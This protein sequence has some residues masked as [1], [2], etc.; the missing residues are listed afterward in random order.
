M[1]LKYYEI[2]FMKPCRGSDVMDSLK[3]ISEGLGWKYEQVASE[4]FHFDTKDLPKYLPKEFVKEVEIMNKISDSVEY[5]VFIR[6][7]PKSAIWVSC[8]GKD[9]F[10]DFVI[11][12]GVYN[13]LEIEFQNIN[14]IETYKSLVNFQKNFD[15]KELKKVRNV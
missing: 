9:Y 10:S 4:G 7:K 1:G 11:P 12:G 5:T 8:I 13:G 14:L 6:K 2:N 15:I 3:K